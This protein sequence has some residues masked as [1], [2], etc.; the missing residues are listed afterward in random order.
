METNNWV[1]VC[2]P[3]LPHPIIPITL[4]TGRHLINKPEKNKLQN[5][6]R[7]SNYRQENNTHELE[8]KE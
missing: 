3:G 4:F 5:T 1:T 2:F 6:S 8:I 7:G